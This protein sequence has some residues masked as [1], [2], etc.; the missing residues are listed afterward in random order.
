MIDIDK[1]QHNLML[2][3]RGQELDPMSD[4]ERTAMLSLAD[5]LRTMDIEASTRWL[6]IAAARLIR[7]AVNGEQLMQAIKRM[8][9]ALEDAREVG[10]I[11][12]EDLMP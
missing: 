5:Q 1:V 9:I 7:M 4:E 6:V 12:D 3:L 10:L 2:M 8:Q 11:I